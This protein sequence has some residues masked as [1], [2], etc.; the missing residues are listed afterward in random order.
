MYARSDIPWFDTSKTIIPCF[1]ESMNVAKELIT[2]RN[3]NGWG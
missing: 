3:I 2:K 1:E